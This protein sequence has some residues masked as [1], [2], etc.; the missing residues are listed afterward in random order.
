[1]QRKRWLWGGGAVLAVA[2]LVVFGRLLLQA[3]QAGDDLEI[4]LDAV[5]NFL[6]K[7]HVLRQLLRL[8]PQLPLQR[9]RPKTAMDPRQE[10]PGV[11][12][13]GDIVVGPPEQPL[14]PILHPV[15]HRKQDD[16]QTLGGGVGLQFLTEEAAVPLRK[17]TVEQ[18]EIRDP[19]PHG[20]PELRTWHWG[21]R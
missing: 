14:D 13:L 12:R 17:H 7:Q 5:V 3:E 10:F 11:K 9:Q 19:G 1:M 20:L 18:E 8:E 15:K 4:V 6:Q 2:A 16:R 21:Y